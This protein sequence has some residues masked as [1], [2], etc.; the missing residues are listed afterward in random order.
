MFPLANFTHLLALVFVKCVWILAKLQGT[1]LTQI[2]IQFFFAFCFAL[3]IAEYHRQLGLLFARIQWPGGCQIRQKCL[4]Q[5]APFKLLL[6]PDFARLGSPD[7][8]LEV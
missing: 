3:S 5:F 4:G 7:V 2:Q 8:N 1:N 6:G